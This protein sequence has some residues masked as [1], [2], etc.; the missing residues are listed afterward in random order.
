MPQIWNHPAAAG[1]RPL[2]VL[3]MRTY[4]GPFEDEVISPVDLG[5]LVVGYAT[6][7]ERGS[8]LTCLPR[9]FFFWTTHPTFNPQ[10]LV[11]LTRRLL[12]PF[13]CDPLPPSA[14]NT[15]DVW[16]VPAHRPAAEETP[17]TSSPSELEGEICFFDFFFCVTLTR[18]MCHVA[19]RRFSL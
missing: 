18:V 17:S 16:V 11:R 15:S 3:D 14:S 9:F 13:L 2:L 6:Q 19:F 4:D 10:I 1:V 7:V 12:L 5:N 8:K